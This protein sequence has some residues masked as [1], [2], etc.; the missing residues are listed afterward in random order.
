[1]QPRPESHVNSTKMMKLGKKRY[2]LGIV[3]NIIYFR[4][5]LLSF[6]RAKFMNI[7][8]AR[9]IQAM[10]PSSTVF[11]LWPWQEQLHRSLAISSSISPAFSMVLEMSAGT[12]LC[13]PLFTGMTSMNLPNPLLK[14]LILSAFTT[15]C[16]RKIQKFTACLAKYCIYPVTAPG[17][18]A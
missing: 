11:C 18:K 1:M 12:A 4:I 5:S 13:N 16:R 14:L 3:F 8:N 10:D 6:F 2:L 9:L 17:T 15:S 7:I